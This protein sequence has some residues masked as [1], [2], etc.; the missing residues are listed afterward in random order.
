M[1]LNVSSGN[2]V[3]FD[4]EYY[5]ESYTIKGDENLKIKMEIE[6]ELGKVVSFDG[7]TYHGVRPCKINTHRIVCVINYN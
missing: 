1:Y 7:L 2:T 5:P 6:P 4:N 3:L